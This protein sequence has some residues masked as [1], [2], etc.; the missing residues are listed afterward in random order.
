[1]A[2]DLLASA[3]RL[4]DGELVERVRHFAAR[5]RDATALLVAHL[6][7]LD[8]RDVHLRAG[9]GS[10]FGYCREALSLSEHEA[11]NH[12]EAAR[13]A[14]RFPVV[15]ERLAE[16]AVTLATVRLVAAHLTADNHAGVLEAVRGKARADVEAVVAR[17]APRPDVPASVRRLPPPR[18]VLPPQAPSPAPAA[19]AALP[20]PPPPPVRV[21]TVR[22]TEAVLPLSPGRYRLQVTIGGETLEK[23]RL[24]R[25]MLRHAVPTGDDAA[26]LDRAL[27]ALLSDLAK[28]R[29]AA[30]EQPRPSRGVAP[31]SRHIPAEVKR[32]VWLRDLGRCAFVG[33][34]GRRCHERAFVEF[35][36]VRPWAVGGET[37]VENVQLRCRRHNE[38]EA[39]VDLG[40]A[41]GGRLSRRDA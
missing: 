33:L 1:M 18:A 11:Y 36:H 6:A 10:L 14:R 16:G 38:L 29:F 2:E 24:A 3:R 30:T 40:P 21:A 19:D 17:L 15:L 25:D 28:K 5:E 7:E 12:V 27:T 9:Y 31:G 37:T 23:L 13:A 4:S 32:T 20:P 8:T 26:V 41:A 22:I 35:H 39:R 34:G